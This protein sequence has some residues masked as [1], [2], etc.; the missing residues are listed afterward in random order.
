MQFAGFGWGAASRLYHAPVSQGIQDF[1]NGKREPQPRTLRDLRIALEQA[2][3]E[4]LFIGASMPLAFARA[5]QTKRALVARLAVP[6]R[7]FRPRECRWT[8]LVA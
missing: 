2:G 4:F 1:E 7:F 6:V 8:Q 3:I 5:I